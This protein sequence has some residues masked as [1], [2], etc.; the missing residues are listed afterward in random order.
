MLRPLPYIGAM[1]QKKQTETPAPA[2]T[3]EAEKPK[4]FGGAKRETDPTRYDDWEINGK[5]VDF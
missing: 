4:E 2:P 3:T 5:C 1:E